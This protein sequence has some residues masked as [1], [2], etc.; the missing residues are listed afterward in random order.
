MNKTEYVEYRAAVARPLEGLTHAS[1]GACQG[2]ADCLDPPEC[3]ECGHE[4]GPEEDWPESWYDSANEPHFSW[5][6]CELCGSSLGGDRYPAH[7]Y[8]T[9]EGRDLIVHFD[10]CVD[11]MYYLEYGCLDDRTM[12]DIE[13]SDDA[14]EPQDRS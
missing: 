12:A 5:S 2:C 3:A 10:V 13:D 7:A 4:Y 8:D 6:A 14:P 11:C 1:S 9:R